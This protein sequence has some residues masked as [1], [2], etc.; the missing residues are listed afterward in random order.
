MTAVHNN[1]A[2]LLK[3]NDKIDEAIDHYERALDIDPGNVQAHYNLSRAR[4]TD[5]ENSDI[6][7]MEALLLEDGRSQEEKSNIHFTLGKIYDD[8][9]DFAK[10]FDHFKQGNDLDNRAPPFD[11]KIHNSL[12]DWASHTFPTWIVSAVSRHM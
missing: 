4:K 10:A 1:D 8:T 12:V 9:E 2:N 3:S 7:K 6:E 11:A 5:T